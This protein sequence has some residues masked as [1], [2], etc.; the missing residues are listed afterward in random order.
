[1]IDRLVV[2]SLYYRFIIITLTVFCI[3]FGILSLKRLPIEAYPDV[4]NVQVQIITQYPGRAAEEVEKVITIPIEKVMNA[5][6][7]LVS[8]RSISI[9]S[10]SVVTV[11]FEDGTN[12]YFARQQVT[13]FMNSAT[14]PGGVQ[15]TLAPLYT[16]IGEIYRYTLEGP[17]D[18][19]LLDLK[20]TEDWVVEKGLRT[21]PGVV[22]VVGFGGPTK[23][24]QVRVIP[25]KLRAYGITLHETFEALAKANINAGG[26][27][28]EHG[29]EVY[30]V[31]GLGLIK[32]ISDIENTVIKARE[33]V[34][35]TVKDIAEVGVGPRVRLGIVGMEER[36]DVVASVVLLRKGD[37][38][39]EVLKRVR[40]KVDELNETLA[41]TGVRIVPY[42]DRTNLIHKT[43]E[44]IAENLLAGVFLVLMIIIVYLGI[45]NIRVAFIVASV[46]PLSL[47]FTFIML[48]LRGVPANL[49]SLGAIDFGIIV[50]GA[51]VVVD[52][53]IRHLNL[54]KDSMALLDIIS[55]ATREVGNPVVF[56]KLILVVAFIPIFS[57]QRVEGRIFSPMVYTLCFAF[58]GSLLFSFTVIPVL[59]SFFLK[60]GAAREGFIIHFLRNLYVPVVTKTV[61]HSWVTVGIAIG[62]L[63]GSLAVVPFLGTEFLPELDEGALWVRVTMPPNISLSTAEGLVHEIRSVLQE[64]P[65]VVNT[66]SQLGRPD[67]GTDVNGFDNVEIFVDLKP[68]S[69]WK[70]ARNRIELIRKMNDR[71]SSIP[72]IILNF[73]QPIKDNVDEAVSGVK[74]ELV[75]K[76]FGPDASK[77]E[78]LASQVVEVMS[79]VKG[80]AD[81]ARERLGG[82]AQVQIEIDRS[83][84]A[85]YG[86]SVADVQEVVEVA[87]GGKVATVVLEGERRFEL[88]VRFLEKEISNIDQIKN[89]LISAS[90]GTLIPMSQ[91]ATV[92]VREGFTRLYREANS[93][94]I[95]VKCSI[96]ERDLGSLVAEGQKKVKA[97]VSLPPGYKLIWSGVFE[98][99]RRAMKRL[100]IIVP[101][102]MFIIVAILYTAFLSIKSTLL[103]MINIIFSLM[104]APFALAVTRLHL[105]VSAMVGMV[106]L[107]GVATMYGVVM[108]SYINQLRNENPQT[109]FREVIIEGA[110]NRF[111]AVL[112]AGTLGI[113]GLLPAAVST[114]IGSEIQR[115]FAV[116]I[117]GG[118]TSA[119]MLSLLVLP[120]LY[121][122]IEGKKGRLKKKVLKGA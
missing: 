26:S 24:Y 25:E 66:A 114:R 99:Q 40:A 71:L 100:A 79:T 70:T 116:A 35:I 20:A 95:A 93:L 98:N 30:T 87:L 43:L 104:G 45:H 33:G 96:R 21:V 22:G 61:S 13:E 73:S 19:S 29:S 88:N 103:V 86:I 44:T 37:N 8:L 10:L 56:A 42:Y 52:N 60:P 112:M 85:R 92:T 77:L 101:V 72:G 64:F 9:F 67:D 38:P 83:K 59:C 65:E 107:S 75:V 119:T 28:I 14:L 1:M 84:I 27:L 31:R 120:A 117:V 12:P 32:T 41:P 69:K 105:S 63:A 90:D 6:P 16:P 122:L 57:F 109:N 58:L 2:F 36:D 48:D 118:L 53:I 46:I 18:I 80:A 108:V 3:G 51:V 82:Q 54:K 4:T 78:E 111:N 47:L 74:G 97:K 76:I 68:R 62:L 121:N 113:L 34:P 39:L 17:P 50:D 15:P 23:Q 94:R 89:I 106:A 115:P 11:V 55:Y 7:R 5:L 110:K 102:C 91:L 49:L 81:L